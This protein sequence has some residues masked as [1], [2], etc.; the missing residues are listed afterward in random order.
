MTRTNYI[1]IDFENV[2]DADLA[3]IAGKPVKVVL[4]LGEQHRK[5]PVALV[6]QLHQYASAVRLVETGCS[7]KNALDLVLASCMGEVKNADPHGYFHILSKDKDFDALIGH[8]KAN[9]LLAARHKSFSEIPVLMNKAERVNFIVTRL[10]SKQVTRAKKRAKLESQIQA[11][12]GK[13][14][15][16]PELQDTI[17]GLIAAKAI[18]IATT[19]EVIYKL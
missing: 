4:V 12:F 15:S 6:R 17:S 2:Q 3:R 1:F 14:L 19:D 18:E 16:E 9:G 13:A 10:K 5:L 8:Y 7:G 11:L